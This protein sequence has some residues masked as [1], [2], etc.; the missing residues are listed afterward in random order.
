MV[1]IELGKASA[2]KG[3]KQREGHVAWLGK[4]RQAVAGGVCEPIA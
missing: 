4:Q 3:K 1:E 2:G